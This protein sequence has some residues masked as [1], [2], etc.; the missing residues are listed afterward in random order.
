VKQVGGKSRLG[1]RKDH[2]FIRAVNAIRSS[3][4]FSR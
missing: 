2:G 4:G 1:C 3:L